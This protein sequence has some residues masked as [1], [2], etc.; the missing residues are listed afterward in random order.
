MVCVMSPLSIKTAAFRKSIDL[1][2]DLVDIKRIPTLGKE[3][4]VIF[5]F[6]NDYFLFYTDP[7][8]PSWRL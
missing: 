1:R 6:M 2:L 8:P 3:L 4:Q 7:G 5:V